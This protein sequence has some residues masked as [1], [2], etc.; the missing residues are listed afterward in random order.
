MKSFRINNMFRLG[1]WCYNDTV[2]PCLSKL[3]NYDD[4]VLSNTKD[5]YSPLFVVEASLLG[6]FDSWEKESSKRTFSRNDCTISVI[7]HPTHYSILIETPIGRLEKTVLYL[8][9][10]QSLWFFMT[11]YELDISPKYNILCE[12]PEIADIIERMPRSTNNKTNE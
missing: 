5:Y 8:N 2:R 7:H 4:V 3:E 11:G 1:D 10:V 6:F 12:V 9:E